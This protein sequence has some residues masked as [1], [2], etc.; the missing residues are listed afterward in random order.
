MEASDVSGVKV[1][2]LSA[3][4]TLPEWIDEAKKHSLRYNAGACVRLFARFSVERPFV[5]MYVSRV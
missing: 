3:G 4:K 2:N 1:Y 5:C